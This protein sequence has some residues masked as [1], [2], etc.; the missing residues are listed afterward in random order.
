MA[1][2]T[3]RAVADLGRVLDMFGGIICNDSGQR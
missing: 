3:K 1:K 2:K